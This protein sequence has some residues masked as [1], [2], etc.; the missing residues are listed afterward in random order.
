MGMNVGGGSSLKSEINVTPL[1]DVVLVLLIIFM[2]II[3]LTQVGYDVNTPEKVKTNLPPPTNNEQLIVRL[4]ANGGVFI[5]KEAVS[6]AN[7][8]GRFREVI[9]NRES[10]LV[11][12]AAD[13]ELLYDRVAAFMDLCRNN[14]AKNIGIVFDDLKGGP[15]A[16]SAVGLSQ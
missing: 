4:D 2:V 13:G 16:S 11:F 1:V 12:F 5:N 7:F 10:K 8:P 14:G 9:K 3:P 6:E 15:A